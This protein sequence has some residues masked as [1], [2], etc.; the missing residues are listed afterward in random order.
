MYNPIAGAEHGISSN[1]FFE[2]KSRPERVL[3]V[4]AGY[5]AVEMSQAQWHQ[6]YPYQHESV[7][8][9]HCWKFFRQNEIISL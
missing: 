9:C 5:I 3:V 6:N 4:G 7:K 8:K 1:E 2:L